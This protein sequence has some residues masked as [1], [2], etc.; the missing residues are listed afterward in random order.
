MEL[1]HA[2]NN[3]L[4]LGYL[5]Q[6]HCDSQEVNE[7]MDIPAHQTWNTMMPMAC[8]YVPLS[9]NDDMLHT[10]NVCIF[11]MT[12]GRGDQQNLLLQLGVR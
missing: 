12:V 9:A 2:S 8:E 4:C 5:G 11:Q 7:V 1:V 10:N 3:F 6:F